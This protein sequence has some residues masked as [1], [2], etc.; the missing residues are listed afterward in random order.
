G[1]ISMNLESKGTLAQ[2]TMK[3]ELA[4]HKLRAIT[5]A[6]TA[7]EK[8]KS[9]TVVQ[10]SPKSAAPPPAEL[11]PT[12][13]EAQVTLAGQDAKLHGTIKQPLMQTLT[14]S[15]GTTLD[16]KPLLEGR[17]FDA[18]ALPISASVDLP[19]SKLDFLP[20]LVPA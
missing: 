14:L 9:S 8:A 18:K 17:P 12:E 15:G 20:R 1:T 2:P 10:P 16:L 7:A 3:L 6:P 19:A 13:F 4:G 11:P 5:P